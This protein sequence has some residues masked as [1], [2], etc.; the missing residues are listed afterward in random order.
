MNQSSLVLLLCLSP[1]VVIF[2]VMKLALWLT[3]TASFR[4]ET[5]RLKRIQHGPYEFYD[6]EEE[7]FF[8]GA[9]DEPEDPFAGAPVEK[10]PMSNSAKVFSALLLGTVAAAVAFYSQD[11]VYPIELIDK[12]EAHAKWHRL[13]LNELPIQYKTEA[14]DAERKIEIEDSAAREIVYGMDY[15]DWKAQFQTEASAEARAAHD[16]THKH[17]S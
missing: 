15:A 10:P 12:A 13:E 14:I 8:N 3:E 4:A 17:E 2:I 6:E 16:K 5:E 9:L 1:L 11:R 7:D